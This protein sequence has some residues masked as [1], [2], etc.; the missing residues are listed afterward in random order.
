MELTPDVL[1]AAYEL[2]DET[3]PFKSWNLPPAEDINFEIVRSKKRLGR[4][5][6]DLSPLKI[7]ISTLY[8]F[9]LPSVLLTMAHEM[10]HVHMHQQGMGYTHG[11]AFKALRDQVCA[12]H[13]F[14]PGQF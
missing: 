8:H 3:E 9:Y 12:V 4:C 2:L 14:D 7:E 13:G 6:C 10:V 5:H 1:R 11:R